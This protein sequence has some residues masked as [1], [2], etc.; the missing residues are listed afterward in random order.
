MARRQWP[1]H[2][3]RPPVQVTLTL[4]AGG[5]PVQRNLLADTEA[6]TARAGFELLLDE[7]DCLVAGGIPS[8]A[9]V[10]GGAYSGSYPVYLIRVQFPDL[11]FDHHLPAVGVPTVPA[12]F[13]GIACFRFWNR[14]QYGNFGDSGQFGLNA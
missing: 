6:G 8:P 7:Q 12:G 9:V 10:L 5:Q 14:F 3:D 2:H 4:A 1:L 13:D 11:G